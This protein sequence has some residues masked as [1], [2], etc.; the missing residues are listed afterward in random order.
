MV[1]ARLLWLVA[2][3]LGSV[4][5]SHDSAG[6]DASNGPEGDGNGVPDR[7][8]NGGT[9]CL[10]DA[11]YRCLDS[12]SFA[13]CAGF[14]I[15]GCMQTCDGLDQACQ[16][17][18]F[19]RWGEAESDPSDCVEDDSVS[20]D[21]GDIDVEDDDDDD[22]DCNGTAIP[23]DTT[24]D[25]CEGLVCGPRKDGQPGGSCQ[26]APEG[27][28]CVDDFDCDLGYTCY[29]EECVEGGGEGALCDFDTD[30]VGNL[31]CIDGFCY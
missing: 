4:A 2:A 28:G 5:C 3:A 18:C 1:H 21:G 10:N 13:K 23:C 30:C 6:A 19:D 12:A 27:G 26:A 31:F 25:C 9:C 8:G 7:D 22:D 24:L 29:N 20:C 11:K 17:S 14:D 16:D 15:N